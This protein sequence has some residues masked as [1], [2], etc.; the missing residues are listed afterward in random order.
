[1][2]SVDN[3]QLGLTMTDSQGNTYDVFDKYIFSEMY[4]HEI[5]NYVPYFELYLTGNNYLDLLSYKDFKLTFQSE[6]LNYDVNLGVI[7]MIPKDNILLIRGW[8]V[9]YLDIRVP[10][11]RYL[12]ASAKEALQNIN[13][14]ENI[15]F[16]DDVPGKIFQVNT[17]NLQQTLGICQMCA[18]TPYWYIGRYQINLEPKSEESDLNVFASSD[19]LIISTNVDTLPVQPENND[20]SPWLS[21]S[22]NKSLLDYHLVDDHDLHHTMAYNK[23]SFTTGPKLMLNKHLDAETDEV[24]GTEYKN[25][26]TDLFPDITRWVLT[27]IMYRYTRQNVDCQ[28]QYYGVTDAIEQQ[29]FLNDNAS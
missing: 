4:V 28:M 16:N 6:S 22:Q 25:S 12:G 11:T 10:Q 2:I 23:K 19:N 15:N 13:I 24:I 8:M 17:T 26:R 3:Y 20:D 5:I 21:Y 14:R 1:M 18:K 7:N 27:S 9:R 29:Q